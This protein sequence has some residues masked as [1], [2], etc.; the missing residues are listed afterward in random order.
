MRQWKFWKNIEYAH[1]VRT[2]R[3]VLVFWFEILPCASPVDKVL[4]DIWEA[5][6]IVGLMLSVE[7]D[8][9]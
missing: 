8:E 4:T 7:K 5:V 3:N 2:Y 6:Y 1:G 9:C